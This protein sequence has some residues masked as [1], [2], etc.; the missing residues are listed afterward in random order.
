M[1]THEHHGPV[2]PSKANMLHLPR[3]AGIQML[4]LQHIMK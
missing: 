3:P 4:L 2:K 1:T